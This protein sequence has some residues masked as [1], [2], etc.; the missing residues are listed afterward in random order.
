MKFAAIGARDRYLGDRYLGDRWSYMEAGRADNPAIVLLHGVGGTR[1]QA[2]GAGSIEPKY[3][4]AAFRRRGPTTGK[5]ATL[6]LAP[7]AR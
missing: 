3:R 4:L 5:M 1:L 7:L 6:P 2:A